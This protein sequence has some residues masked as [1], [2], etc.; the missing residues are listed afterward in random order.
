MGQEKIIAKNTKQ[1]LLSTSFYTDSV[2]QEIYNFAKGS[3]YYLI[4]LMPDHV[5]KASL[6]YTFEQGNFIPSQG[7]TSINAGNASTEG[8]A[9]L[10]TVKLFGA[11]SYQKTF[12]DSTRFAHQTRSNVSTPYYFGSPAYVHYERSVYTFN[13]MA[14]KNFLGDKLNL[15]LGTDYKVGDHYSTNDPRGSVGEYQFNL[16]FSLGYKV[17]KA[18]GFGAAYRTGYGQE[19]VTIGYKNPRYYESSFYPMYYNHLI[20]GYG[21]G[22]PALSAANRRYTDNQKRNGADLYMDLN[23]EN[24]GRFHL[25][26]TY[27]KETQR[28]FYSTSSGFDDFAQYNL[29]NTDVNFLWYMTSGILSFGTAINYSNNAGK[30]FNLQYQAN[31]YRYND[32]TSSIKIFLSKKGTKN[33]YNHFVR[34]SMYNEE[35]VDG[36]KAN[37]IYFSNLYLNIGS[38]FTRFQDKQRFL[39]VN[40]SAEYKIAL[41]DQFQVT[42]ANEGYFTRYVIYHD[43]LYNTASSIGG[44]ITAEYGFPFLK[45]MQAGFKVEARYNDK[46]DQK[47]LDRNVVSSPGNDRFSSN[48][49]LN[50]YF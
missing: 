27:T 50:L 47:T 9:K 33:T 19:R 10:G 11:F 37:D 12:E 6:R 34:A 24:L 44:K 45:T 4:N 21:E 39:S 36:T 15:G 7:S 25:K 14:G 20:N 3:S 5:S 22:R 46:L 40:L 8:T 18:F 43:Y 41:N 42:Q 16:L 31:N 35:R 29:A 2:N 17:N 38:G 32:E 48:I 26:T 13:A 49:S 30:D 28:Y 23:S 1:T